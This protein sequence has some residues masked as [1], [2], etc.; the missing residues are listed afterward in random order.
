MEFAWDRAGTGINAKRK[1]YRKFQTRKTDKLLFV[2]SIY[3]KQRKGENH[4]RS[5]GI[6]LLLFF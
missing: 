3:P 2:R 1:K 5:S 4:T 6:I